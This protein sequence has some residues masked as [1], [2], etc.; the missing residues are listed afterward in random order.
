MKKFAE[1]FL[2]LPSLR[3]CS[4]ILQAVVFQR[5]AAYE[6]DIFL[7]AHALTMNSKVTLASVV[8]VEAESPLFLDDFYENLL[9]DQA[10]HK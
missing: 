8:S 6:Y 10:M 1:K 4:E 5:F 3:M 9:N 7:M 2:H